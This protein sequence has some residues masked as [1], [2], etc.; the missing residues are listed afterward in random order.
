MTATFKLWSAR[1]GENSTSSIGGSALNV[2]LN[3]GDILNGGQAQLLQLRLGALLDEYLLQVG[4]DV[5]P[6]ATALI[7]LLVESRLFSGPFR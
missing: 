6:R 2:L 4:G 3:A 5:V 7:T 1:S